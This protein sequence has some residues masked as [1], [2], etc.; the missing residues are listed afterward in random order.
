METSLLTKVY[1]N[2]WWLQISLGIAFIAF[3]I[4]IALVP[5]EGNAELSLFFA[6]AILLTGAFEIARAVKNKE[7]SK[8]WGWYLFGEATDT[9]VGIIFLSYLEL[10]ITLLPILLGIWIIFRGAFYIMVSID[11]RKV[12]FAT[13]FVL[14]FFGIL[15]VAM[16]LLILAKPEIG[17]YTIAYATSIAF[18]TTGVFRVILGRS[19]YNYHLG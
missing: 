17:S 10:T 18:I 11:V 13:W 12:A 14:L 15:I 5:K 4:W 8:N 7:Y 3:G 19:L 9:I 6:I 2:L 1:T 16:G